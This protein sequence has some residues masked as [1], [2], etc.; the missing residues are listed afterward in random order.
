MSPNVAL[1]LCLFVYSSDLVPSTDAAQNC[2]PSFTTLI[3]SAMDVHKNM[4][5]TKIAAKRDK[6]HGIHK[7]YRN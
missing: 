3:T 2:D 4:K 5:V 1:F 7:I 6:Y